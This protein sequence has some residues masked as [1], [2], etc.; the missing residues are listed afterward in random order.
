MKKIIVSLGILLNVF[1]LASCFSGGGGYVEP[2]QQEHKEHEWTSWEIVHEPRCDQPGLERRDCPICGEFEER[3][4]EQISHQYNLVETH[5]GNCVGVGYERYECAYCGHSYHK[6]LP[7]NDNHDFYLNN[8]IDPYCDYSGTYDGYMEYICSLC[9][10]TKTEVIPNTPCEFIESERYESTCYEKGFIRYVCTKNPDHFYDE[11]LEG[12][13]NHNFYF[14]VFETFHVKRCMYCHYAEGSLV[15]IV[16]PDGSIEEVIGQ[17]HRFGQWIIET[18]AT[19]ENTGSRYKQCNDCEYKV[20]EE[21]PITHDYNDNGVCTSCGDLAPTEGLIYELLN[22]DT[23]QVVGISTNPEKIIIPNYYEGKLVSSIDDYAFE[24]KEFTSIVLPKSITYYSKNA[25][26]DCVDLKDIYYYGKLEDWMNIDFDGQNGLSTNTVYATPVLKGRSIYFLNEDKEYYQ[27]TNLVIPSSV[28]EIKD[29]T[30]AQFEQLT[31]VTF[32]ENITSIGV[33][34]FV[35][36]D[37][38]ETIDVYAKTIGAGAFGLCDK[39]HTANIHNAV[40]L[41]ATFFECKELIN[42]TLPNTLKALLDSTFYGCR[43]LESLDLPEGLLKIGN[44]NFYNC[45]ALVN[46]NIPS[47]VVK[48]EGYNF[49]S[50]DNL[51]YN[52]IDGMYYLGN[53]TNPKMILIWTNE[54][55][56]VNYVVDENVRFI[57]EDAIEANTMESITI[58][59]TVI[60]IN[61][62]IIRNA[63]VLT[64]ITTPLFTSDLINYFNRTPELLTKVELLSGEV[65]SNCFDEIITL[66]EV[67]INDE[68]ILEHHSGLFG[69]NL[70]TRLTIPYIDRI[71]ENRSLSHILNNPI[72]LEYLE[73][74]KIESIDANVFKQVRNIEEIV[75]PDCIKAVTGDVTSL[76]Y[77]PFNILE[78][79]YYLGN[80]NN[81]YLVLISVDVTANSFTVSDDTKVISEGAFSFCSNLEYTTYKNVNYIGDSNNPFKYAISVDTD[82]L[83]KVE[84]HES[85]EV[86]Y[87]TFFINENLD[88]EFGASVKEIRTNFYS[89]SGELS[90][91]YNGTIN[92]WLNIIFQEKYS[93]PMNLYQ[94]IYTKENGEYKLLESLIL[95]DS[96]K[97]IGD[98]QFAGLS[99]KDLK[100]PNDLEYVGKYSF[101]RST[102]TGKFDLGNLSTISE[103]MF[104]FADISNFKLSDSVVRIE[105]YAFSEISLRELYLPESVEYIGEYAFEFNQIYKLEMFAVDFISNE[106]FAGMNVSELIFNGDVNDWLTITFEDLSSNPVIN[107]TQVKFIKDEKEID[108]SNL[109][110]DIEEVGDYQFANFYQVYDLKLTN[111]VKKI[112]SHSFY[113][114]SISTI[115]IPSSLTII[116]DHA[117]ARCEIT[118]SIV[119]PNNV[120]EIGFGVFEECSIESLELPFLGSD[121]DD[122]YDNN[123]GWIFGDRDHG[124]NN[125]PYLDSL[126]TVKIHNGEIGEYAFARTRISE[127]ILVNQKHIGDYAFYQCDFIY[128]LDLSMISTIGRN[129]FNECSYLSKLYLSNELTR[130]YEDA[131]DVSFSFERD[132]YF[133]GSI[134]DW[135]KVSLSSLGSNPIWHGGK[136]YFM[137]DGEYSTIN[138]LVIPT[139]VTSLGGYLFANNQ[140]IIEVEIP[141]SVTY[142]GDSIFCNAINIEKMTI[143]YCFD[144]IDHIFGE[145]Y[146]NGWHILYEL[147]LLEGTLTEISDNNAFGYIPN[148]R[149][150][151][152]PSNIERIVYDAF[153]GIYLDEFRYMGSV[154]QWMNVELE[155]ISSN[156]G[157]YGSDYYF[158]QNGELKLAT[159]IEIPESFTI[160]S[161]YHFWGCESVTDVYLHTFATGVEFKDCKNIT[162]VYYK[163]TMDKWL[164]TYST[165]TADTNPNY[166]GSHFYIYENGEYVNAPSDIRLPEDIVELTYNL[167]GIENIKNITI[168]TNIAGVYSLYGVE[169]LENIYYEGTIDNWLILRHPN[170][171]PAHEFYTKNSGTGQYELLRNLNVNYTHAFLNIQGM[172]SLESVTFENL[173]NHIYYSSFRDL[174]NL[175]NV[176]IENEDTTLDEMPFINCPNISYNIYENGKYL[177]NNENPY[178]LLLDTVD[179]T[180]KEFVMHDDVK[181][182][183]NGALSGFDNI[184]RIITP[185]NIDYNIFYGNGNYIIPQTLI[186]LVFTK[187]IKLKYSQFSTV[188]RIVLKEAINEVD[189]S[190][191]PFREE[192]LEEIIFEKESLLKGFQ[193]NEYEFSSKIKF[194]EYNNAYYLG[195]LDNPYMALVTMIDKEASTV[196]IHQDTIT[197]LGAAF[198]NMENVTEI[199][200][201][202]NVRVINPNTFFGCTSLKTVTMKNVEYIGDYAFNGCIELENLDLGEK[203]EELG[204][205]VFYSDALPRCSKLKSITLPNTLKRL[206]VASLGGLVLD[207]LIIPD[208]VERMHTFVIGSSTIK[209]LTIPFIGEDKDHPMDIMD[210]YFD[211]KALEYLNITNM[212]YITSDVNLEDLPNLITLKIKAKVIQDSGIEDLPSLKYLEVEYESLIGSDCIAWNLELLEVKLITNYDTIGRDMFNNCNKLQ[213]IIL[214]ESTIV[215]CTGAFMN[216]NSLEYIVI[217][218]SVSTIGDS[219][220]QN[221]IKLFF[222]SEYTPTDFYGGNTIYLP[223]QWEY[224]DGVPTPK[225][226]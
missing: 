14:E 115:Q 156:P 9:G 113:N 203:L 131:F 15:Q 68:C 127:L 86:I 114:L 119:I 174:P 165:E 124:T 5:E 1:I 30:F 187:N 204:K 218:E 137:I 125:H 162:N 190:W 70:L 139:T 19:C 85:T 89:A 120:D 91:Y 3:E 13:G 216:C 79:G 134:E 56:I 167:V 141:T 93:N 94:K 164:A 10:Y 181:E 191:M 169:D 72:Y 157:N 116:G 88:F 67:I 136:M 123:I 78:N 121:I 215:I 122:D 54:N 12:E 135:C 175:V 222:E 83:T 172:K 82:N 59:S 22:D 53:E 117:F 95:D 101:F 75:L 214:P 118:G 145:G 71:D 26:Y 74:T 219:S 2:T 185:I 196:D 34:S 129:A 220:F 28:T 103:H 159:T 140:D 199:N 144:G 153:N 163:D 223:G 186:E 20:Y 31:S 29:F 225:Q 108:L 6:D 23:Y 106:A 171:I 96:V 97:V 11:P 192:N 63:S 45:D 210:M 25:F 130:I 188:K 81:P 155:G 132:I 197:I 221:N 147:I 104:Q 64:E 195:S 198:S 16:H 39:L 92:D 55:E 179:K 142:I 43:K 44:G 41:S 211:A 49:Y 27:L 209:R 226:N 80:D 100:L 128:T 126:T 46:I 21:L 47:T 180:S 7:Q 36:C 149:K 98:Y 178:I 193:Y 57:E 52:I 38:L 109:V 37:N 107:G 202:D 58:P 207:E 177:G 4:I 42:I 99:I 152:L 32:H 194:T 170:D 17:Y 133:D 208:S 168:P 66:K 18:P 182:I 24:G 8:T 154:E 69:D 33:G 151:T 50:C 77:M 62:P 112:G 48:Y 148:L 35:N 84:L 158:M 200:I 161:K 105:D 173:A 213:S 110:I 143:P 217:P 183:V 138:K 90:L 201:P 76:E 189:T 73:F 40:E 160:R 224:V 206:N 150:F 102:I 87:D 65:Y 184:E 166:Y 61:Y 111:K 60:G 146:S 205:H 212:T 51:E 176:T